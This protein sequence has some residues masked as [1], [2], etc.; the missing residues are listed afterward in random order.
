MS[1]SVPN[2]IEIVAME[3]DSIQYPTG[4]GGTKLR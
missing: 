1:D 4:I 3:Q 2:D